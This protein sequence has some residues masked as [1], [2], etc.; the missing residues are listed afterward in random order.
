MTSS[1]TD[2][3]VYEFDPKRSGGLGGLSFEEGEFA[4]VGYVTGGRELLS[5]IRS[6]DVVARARLVAGGDRLVIPIASAPVLMGTD[7]L[8][9]MGIDGR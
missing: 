6:G 4:V 7:N 2:W 1:A 3:F 5:Q 8:F 9:L